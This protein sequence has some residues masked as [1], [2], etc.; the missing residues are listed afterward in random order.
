M[1]PNEISTPVEGVSLPAPHQSVQ[2]NT[3]APTAILASALSATLV[4]CGGGGQDDAPPTSDGLQA[5]AT[6]TAALKTDGA[7]LDAFRFLS[8]TTFGPTVT[9]TN[10]LAAKMRKSGTVTAIRAW[11]NGQMALPHSSNHRSETE[12]NFKTKIQYY[13]LR[14]EGAQTA[15][16]PETWY[17]RSSHFTSVWWKNALTAPDQLRLRVAFALSEILVISITGNLDM[18]PYMC[19]DFYDMLVENAF[20]NYKDLVTKVASHPAMGSYLSHLGNRRP[21]PSIGRIPDQNFAREIMQL[22]TIGLYKLNMDGSLQLDSKGNAIETYTPADIRTLS[23]VFTGWSWAGTDNFLV[24]FESSVDK[25]DLQTSPMSPYPEHHSR[26]SDFPKAANGK[27][28][29]LGKTL[30]VTDLP[31]GLGN[32][33]ANRKAALDIIFDH[34]NIA[35]FI[36]RQMIQRLVTSNPST[37]YVNYVAW[38]FRLSGWDLSAL[39]KAILTHNEACKSTIVRR[40]RTYGKLKEPILRMTQYLRA[41]SVKSVGDLF[42]IN[43]MKDT[44]GRGLAQLPLDSPSVFNFFRPGYIAPGTRMAKEGKVAPEMQING[45]TDLARYTRVM[46]RATY[47]GFGVWVN[48]DGTPRNE[49]SRTEGTPQAG[50]SSVYADLA[51]EMAMLANPSKPLFADR[52]ADVIASI[53]LKLFGGWMSPGL[54]AHLA[55]VGDPAYASPTTPYGDSWANPMSKEEFNRLTVSTL[56]FLATISPEYVVQR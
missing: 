22:F 17:L 14:N 1:P 45:E 21:D 48:A 2:A 54:R 4:A 50:S 37:A 30:N 43:A 44:E 16:G 6:A 23:N 3:Q 15:A 19:A 8:Q 24:K 13:Y 42:V 51:P 27:V 31:G 29:L 35:P 25:A 7:A 28:T 39:V 9:D 11:I 55:K 46:Q 49:T 18:Y 36:A 34:P 40:D 56:L 20:G 33:V 10:D 32:P 26:V 38:A 12:A 5:Q 52:V 47:D 41:F 53:N